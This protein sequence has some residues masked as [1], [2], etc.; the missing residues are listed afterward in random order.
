L[1]DYTRE[2]PDWD[3]ALYPGLQQLRA[4]SWAIGLEVARTAR[5]AGLGR[6]LDDERLRAALDEFIWHPDYPAESSAAAVSSPAAPMSTS[7]G[8]N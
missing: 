1:A 6:T 4:V 5:A 8:S 3:G 2:Q 7:K